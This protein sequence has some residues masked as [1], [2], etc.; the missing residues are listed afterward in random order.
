MSNDLAQLLRSLHLR[1]RLNS[2]MHSIIL[3]VLNALLTW[4]S[5]FV[6]FLLNIL[7]ISFIF[8]LY[9]FSFCFYNYNS[10][11]NN[12][13]CIL[14]NDFLSFF[15]CFFKKNTSIYMRLACGVKSQQFSI[16]FS[17]EPFNLYF[18]L[19][20]S[21]SKYIKICIFDVYLFS[22]CVVI[23]QTFLLLK[24]KRN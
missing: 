22:F 17:L 23:V 7:L 21:L 13:C 20:I 9:F 1:F 12:R 8:S 3:L 11:N 15:A 18:F 6:H 5:L 4:I 24:K 16:F 10:Y 19:S 2:L 14:F